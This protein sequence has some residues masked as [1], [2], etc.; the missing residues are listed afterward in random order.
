VA[1]SGEADL[2]AA[3]LSYLQVQGTYRAARRARMQISFS[4]LGKGP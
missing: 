1:D 3:V 4:T 2:V